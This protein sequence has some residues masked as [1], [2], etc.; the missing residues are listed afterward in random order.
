VSIDNAGII[1]ATTYGAITQ[2]G[3][4][5]TALTITNAGQIDASS[6]ND[7]IGFAAGVTN[8]LIVDG[9]G[10]F[11][12]IVDGGNTLGAA[13]ASTLELASATGPGTLSG[14]GTQ[15]INFATT[16]VDA[17]ASWTATGANILAG[18]LIN[19]GD[20]IVGDAGTLSITGALVTDS[21]N[22]GTLGIGA[23]AT[24]S[25]AGTLNT[26]ESLMFDG[27]DGTAIFGTPGAVDGTIGGFTFGDTLLLSG[28]TTST[29]EYVAGAGLEVSNGT[30]THTLDITGSF[31]TGS[32][33]VTDTPEGTE[34]VLCYMRGTRIA[35]PA[36]EVAVEALQAGDAVMTRFGG[37]RRI[38]WIGRQS[39]GAR[40]IRGN[41]DR[42]PVR[43]AAG[44]LGAGLPKC[45]LFVSPGHSML[46]GDVLVL[47]RDLVNGITITQNGSSE[48]VHYYQLEFETHDCVLA[49]GVWSESFCD[50]ADL[51]G[52]FHNAAEFWTL[53][54]EHVTPAEHLM[55]APRPEAGYT[56]AAALYPAVARAAALAPLGQLR[57]VLD[58][59]SPDGL[60]RGWAQ[61]MANPELPVLL[62]IAL[63]TRL[64][65]T[66]LACDHRPDLAAAGIGTGRAAFSFQAPRLSPEEQ[67]AIVVRRVADGAVLA[68]GTKWCRDRAA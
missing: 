61:D 7:A 66:T 64:L 67:A 51:R 34:V 3:S 55:C 19:D 49:E 35:T 23:N 4:Y 60:I 28:F 17:G 63:G 33:E 41:R 46:L 58:E 44:A 29:Y 8:R 20:L 5:A 50:H 36:G 12:G 24:L 42:L 30:V 32:F 48:D 14:L 45:D 68:A 39:Y 2:K 56:L 53:Y 31:S 62:A 37:Y 6:T 13:F 1:D 59:V 16:A 9:G 18:T 27:T 52:Q 54:P 21:G 43:I 65:G 25:L 11:R 22:N 47:A 10:T 38:K 40:F 26:T 15:F 57:G